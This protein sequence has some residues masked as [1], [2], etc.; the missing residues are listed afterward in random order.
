MLNIRL[1]VNLRLNLKV[2]IIHE[3][4]LKLNYILKTKT[5]F[6][7]NE[8][9]KLNCMFFQII[10]SSHKINKS[11]NL[12]LNRIFYCGYNYLSLAKYTH[13]F[14]PSIHFSST[15]ELSRWTKI[16]GWSQWSVA[17]DGG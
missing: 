14:T 8:Y 12:M 13:T 9:L 5:V 17:D 2:R 7:K 11:I 6:V 3:F 16:D 15:S 1:A 10:F 4:Q